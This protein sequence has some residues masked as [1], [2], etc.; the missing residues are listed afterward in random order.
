MTPWLFTLMLW[1]R[2]PGDTY[3]SV[4][5]EG[6]CGEVCEGA[7]Y[8]S[9]YEGFV[10]QETLEE[11]RERYRTLAR[12][13]ERA[14]EKV[15]CVTLAGVKIEGCV[16]EPVALDKKTKK[17]LFGPVF[18]V[19]ALNGV[20]IPESGLREDVQAGR[21]FAKKCP[22]DGPSSIAGVC[23]PSDDG[24]MGRGPGGEACVV[25]IHPSIGW[26]FADGDPEVLAR[27]EAGDKRAQEAIMQSL[28]GLDEAS[29]ERCFRAGLRM[30]LHSFGYCEWWR[31]Q[32]ATA[33][34]YDYAMYS[35][36]GTGTSCVSP[37]SGKTVYRAE[38]FRKL[39]ARAKLLAKQA[40]GGES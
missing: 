16:P 28:V 40:R 12:A 24:G 32:N 14:I 1:A 8:S 26:R 19:A 13:E 7:K 2:P 11:G 6:G 35:L 29:T 5:L 15:L 23:G 22:K 36:Y 20:A 9:F 31:R 34:N 18:A 4:V 17:L 39:Y 25:Q 3:F 38:L 10:R 37:N 27:A 21:G 33:V 30:L